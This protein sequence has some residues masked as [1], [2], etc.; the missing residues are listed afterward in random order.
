MAYFAESHKA[1]MLDFQM[2]GYGSPAVELAYFFA[3][4]L[5]VTSVKE[6]IE[7]IKLYY[8]IFVEKGGINKKRY[9][10]DQFCGDIRLAQIEFAVAILVRKAKF[11]TPKTIQSFIEKQ[12]ESAYQLQLVIAQREGRWVQKVK[13]I[14]KTNPRFDYK[15][16]QRLE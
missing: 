5:K 14:W 6:E 12:G 4:N 16:L 1:K 3:S 15:L 10:L 8:S 11:D 7:L 2:W 13:E 9:S